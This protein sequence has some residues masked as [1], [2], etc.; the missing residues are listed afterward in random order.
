MVEVELARTSDDVDRALDVAEAV[1][2]SRPVTDPIARAMELAGW[3]CA[4]ARDGGDLVGMCAGFVGMH[5]DAPHLHSHLAAVLP[6]AQG[7]GIGQAMKRHQR[8]WCLD[9]GIPTVTWTFDPLVRENARFNLQH[10]GALGTQYLVDLYG[11][12]DDDINRGQP[13]DRL[14]V[15]WDLESA[16]T[17]AAIDGRLPP[18]V[19]GAPGATVVPT[20]ADI[21]GLRRTAPDEAL[22]WRLRV[23][24]AMVAAFDAG[25]RVTGMTDDHAYVLSPEQP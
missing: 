10:L 24:D 13:S 19:P 20:P 8:Q 18:P 1:W 17:R 22:R 15:R 9:R 23:R 5:D 25:L 2:G 6:R 3:Y 4:V 16:R 21:T 12:M 11:A 14:L 7:R